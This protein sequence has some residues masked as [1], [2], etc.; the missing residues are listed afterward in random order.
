MD[1]V[2]R[3]YSCI[4]NDEMKC[5]RKHLNVD[6]KADCEDMEIDNEKPVEDVSRD[7][8]SHEPEVSPY[9]HCSNINIGCGAGQCIFNNGGECYSNGIFVGS[10]LSQAPCNSF[11]PK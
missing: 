8:F 5:A 3:K 6:K 4:Y 10:E 9:R 7:M 2:C 1:I 11:T